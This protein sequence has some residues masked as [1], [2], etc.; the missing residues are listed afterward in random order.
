MIKE[1]AAKVLNELIATSE[2]GSKG[3]KE[4]AEKA[5]DPNLKV[6]FTERAQEC[7]HAVADLQ[8]TVQELGVTA[9]Q[10]GSISGAA[11]RGWVAVKAAVANSNVAVLEEVERGEDY[12][13]AIYGKAIKSDLPPKAKALVERQY[14]GV[15]RNHD[16]IRDLRNR[17][18]AAA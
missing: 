2:D 18:R 16:R 3:F 17:Y 11:H 14:Q 8:K 9:K 15:L 13:K 5:E 12:A 4:A 7:A 6:L 1:E 10:G